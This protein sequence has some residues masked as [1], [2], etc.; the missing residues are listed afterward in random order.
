MSLCLTLPTPVSYNHKDDKDKN[1]NELDNDKD[2]NDKDDSDKNSKKNVL[3][4]DHE[5]KNSYTCPVVRCWIDGR[6]MGVLKWSPMG[7]IYICY[8]DK[9]IYIYIYV[10]IFIYV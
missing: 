10:Y 3:K 7:Y 2:D 1:D 4:S 8:I 5:Y 6:S 9:Y